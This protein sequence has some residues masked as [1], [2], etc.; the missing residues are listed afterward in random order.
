MILIPPHRR[1]NIIVMSSRVCY[2]IHYE[3]TTG[4]STRGRMDGWMDGW[5]GGWVDGWVD[6]WMGGFRPHTSTQHCQRVINKI[7]HRRL[8]GQYCMY[9][10]VRTSLPS[11]V[12]H[13]STQQ[14]TVVPVCA[15]LTYVLITRTCQFFDL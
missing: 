14:R 12:V 4:V 3:I 6:G 7:T 2:S 5:M 10:T 11:L 15:V 13:Y 1:L 9:S 8:Q